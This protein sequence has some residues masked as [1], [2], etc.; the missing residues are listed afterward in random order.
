MPYKNI[1][2]RKQYHREYFI[3]NRERLRPL[4]KEW[5]RKWR[6][7]NRFWVNEQSLERWRKQPTEYKKQQLKLARLRYFE[8]RTQVVKGYGG[9]CFCCG[10]NKL[11][12]LVINHVNG[13]GNKERKQITS[14]RSFITKII[15]DNFPNKYNLLCHNC[16]SSFGHYGYC[17]HKIKK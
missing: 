6:A 8:L 2:K 4:Q 11:E 9:K 14:Y 7:S 16:N 15:K 5:A 13:G 17:P 12:F 3:K 1:E 10:E